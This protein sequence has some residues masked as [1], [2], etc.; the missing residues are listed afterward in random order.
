L[1]LILVSSSSHNQFLGLGDRISYPS[2]GGEETVNVVSEFTVPEKILLAALDLEEQ[3][4][5]PFSAEALIVAVWQ[6]FPKTFGLKGFADLYPDSNKVLAS[7]MGEKGLTRKG[8]LA[9]MGQKLYA[10]TRDGRQIVRKLRQGEETPMPEPVKL[11]RDQ[12]K[13]INGLFGSTALQ[14]FLEGRKLELNFADASRY[15]GIS[16]N[17]HG[18][19]LDGKLNQFRESLAQVDRHVGL[20]ET[21][22]SNGRAVSAA[23]I[24]QLGDLHTYLE[25]RFGRHLSV[26]RSRSASRS[27]T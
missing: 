19:Q 7:I 12:E 10:V 11:T 3:G 14:K 1:H 25:E 22:L 21:T 5:S 20:G 15:W 4:Q 17:M 18:A 9:K 27:Q 24:G 6:K 16:E 26:L 2:I 8:W 23:D 13:F